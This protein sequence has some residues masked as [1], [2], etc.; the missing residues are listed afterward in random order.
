MSQT[1]LWPREKLPPTGSHAELNVSDA[2]HRQLPDNWT[3]WHCLR[4]RTIFP[5]IPSAYDTS[6]HKRYVPILDMQNPPRPGDFLA[7]RGR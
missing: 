2:L 4:I 1:G 3:A 6:Q 7:G 5:D